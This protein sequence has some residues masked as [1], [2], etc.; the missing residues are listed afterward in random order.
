VKPHVL[1]FYPHIALNLCVSL[2][3]IDYIYVCVCNIYIAPLVLDSVNLSF[4]SLVLGFYDLS[5]DTLVS[6]EV[7]CFRCERFDIVIFS[8]R[9]NYLVIEV[10]RE[11]LIL[12]ECKNKM[13][14]MGK[15]VGKKYF[16][17]KPTLTS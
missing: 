3:G 17:I 5:F 12:F 6:F 11:T 16:L 13:Q 7:G 9:L 2:R 1:K 4:R 14:S 15:N 8:F 10:L